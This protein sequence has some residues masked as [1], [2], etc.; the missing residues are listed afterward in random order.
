MKA[1]LIRYFTLY[2]MANFIST[3]FAASDSSTLT[4][5]LQGV[6]TLKANFTQQTRDGRGK[7]TQRAYGRMA[8]ERPGKFRWEITKPIPQLIIANKNTLWVYDP[9]LEQVT[10]R[11]LN[12]S[13]GEAPALL[14]SH[15]NASLEKGFKVSTLPAKQ[16]NMQWFSLTPKKP[17][18][19]FEHIE[20]GFSN[21]ELKQMRLKDHLGNM[22]AIQFT[23]IQNNMAVNASLF[24]FKAPARVDVID[25]RKRH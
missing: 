10:V 16:A 15:D 1:M 6:K 23:N 18:N 4:D 8:L 2:L 7:E 3:A 20:I 25:E 11:N 17:D 13:A 12:Y 24:T 5:L 21:K 19:M 9:D 14:L 22:T